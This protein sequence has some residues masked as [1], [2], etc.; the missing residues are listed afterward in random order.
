MST[1]VIKATVPEALLCEAVRRTGGT[2]AQTI[3]AAI[4]WALRQ[5]VPNAPADRNGPPV[6][7]ILQSNGDAVR[8]SVR[9]PTQAA[10][11]LR[12]QA[13]RRGVSISVLVAEALPHVGTEQ[14]FLYTDGRENRKKL[15]AKRRLVRENK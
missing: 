2:R 15:Y 12:Q 4:T 6:K 11:A 8:V 10:Q 5:P 1:T 3:R 7:A 9:A 14:E 13:A